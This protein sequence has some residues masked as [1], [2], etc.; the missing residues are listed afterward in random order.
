MPDW[1][2]SVIHWLLTLSLTEDSRGVSLSSGFEKEGSLG[3]L[4]EEPPVVI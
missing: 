4:G 3:P 2:G 1:L